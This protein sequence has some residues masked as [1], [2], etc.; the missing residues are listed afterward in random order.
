[1]AL[2][3]MRDGQR[4]FQRVRVNARSPFA[5]TLGPEIINRVLRRASRAARRRQELE[6]AWSRCADPAWLRWTQL[7]ELRRGE[8]T[9][10]VAEAAL[11]FELNRCAEG[12]ARAMSAWA[13]S[14][15]R[16]RFIVRGADFDASGVDE[17]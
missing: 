2:T 9:V 5:T 14:V 10:Q 17:A 7:G 1:M 12:L 8:L 6:A 3:P 11:C 15:K 16:I 13:P 4:E